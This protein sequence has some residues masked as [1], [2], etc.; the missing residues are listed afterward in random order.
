M[1][2]KCDKEIGSSVR[3]AGLCIGVDKY[4]HF[5]TLHNAVRDAEHFYKKLKATKGCRPKIIRDP[6]RKTLIKEIRSFCDEIYKLA[7]EQN[8]PEVCF[9]QYSGH[10]IQRETVY[11]VPK[12]AE[13]E[14]ETELE[15]ELLSLSKLLEILRELDECIRQE[16]GRRARGMV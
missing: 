7:K 13:I 6:T 1:A 8:P 9:L 11:L 2:T 10:G 15:D 4:D 16:F 5:D 3:V 12:D 14:R